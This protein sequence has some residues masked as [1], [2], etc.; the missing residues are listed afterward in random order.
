[1]LELGVYGRS[2][3]KLYMVVAFT[4]LTLD[5]AVANSCSA[6]EL[7]DRL[8]A[9]LDGIR[10]TVEDRER[11]WFGNEFLKK[12]GADPS[13][14]LIT[15]DTDCFNPLMRSGQTVKDIQNIDAS[16]VDRYLNITF[17]STPGNYTGCD[18]TI[19]Q[20]D[21][22]V[23]ILNPLST[24][25][26]NA[27]DVR[28]VPIMSWESEDGKLFTIAV[29][30]VANGVIHGLYVNI[31]GNDVSRAEVLKSYHGPK[32]A[33]AKANLYIFLL[34]E[35]PGS[36]QV[37]TEWKMK[38]NSW[39]FQPA[40]KI[41]EF[42]T[43]YNLAGPKGVNNLLAWYDRYSV[44]YM[45]QMGISSNCVPFV[46]EAL[47]KHSR[48]FLPEDPDLSVFMRIHFENKDIEFTYCCKNKKYE[49]RTFFLDP[50]ENDRI[51]AAETRSSN[52][53][54]ILLQMNKMFPN[55]TTDFKGK[56]Y[57]VLEL[58]PDVPF[59]TIGTNELPLLHWLSLNNEVNAAGE[60]EQGTDLKSYRGPMPPDD[61]T[62]VYYFMLYE[63]KNG[64][65][66]KINTTEDYAG[67][68]AEGLETRCLFNVSHFATD[69]DLDLVAVS[70]MSANNDDFVN[71]RN[72]KDQNEACKGRQGYSDPC[73]SPGDTGGA[74]SLSYAL[75]SLLSMCIVTLLQL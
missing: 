28:D 75:Y 71:F 40:F 6:V 30:D 23:I 19:I 49:E 26:I 33:Q 42:A 34:Y 22:K 48:P 8:E 9:C 51:N 63:Q 21:T 58:D 7:A 39:G 74:T 53:V 3:M 17:I 1:M 70:W 57:T 65:S 4:A 32:N 61:K 69:N 25:T 72:N 59:S 38:L 67:D 60:L 36:I 64:Q 37:S 31:P 15:E 20:R 73:N 62:H 68:C 12:C 5:Y 29:I 10:N 47:L 13:K 46:K 41:A 45:M 35:Q 54:K 44:N 18:H 2:T 43:A 27:W 16:G 50:S 11:Y 56:R 52:P 55:V 66:L 14:W 24:D